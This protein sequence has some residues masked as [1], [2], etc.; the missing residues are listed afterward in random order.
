MTKIFYAITRKNKEGKTV[1]Y[2]YYNQVWL[3]EI[4]M[5]CLFSEK[6]SAETVINAHWEK[7]YCEVTAFEL[8]EIEN[9]INHIH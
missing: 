5:D 3:T 9:D 4:D 7:G 1:Y 8:K 2:D 6:N